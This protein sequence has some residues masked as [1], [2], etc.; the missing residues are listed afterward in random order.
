MGAAGPLDLI[1]QRT[2]LLV[3]QRLRS[4]AIVIA[5]LA[6][7][8]QEAVR[9][10]HPHRD[11][12]GAV[13]AGGLVTRWNTYRV[14]LRRARRALRTAHPA[15]VT[16]P[17]NLI[18]ERLEGPSFRGEAAPAPPTAGSETTSSTAE[19]LE[20]LQRAR[21]TASKDYGRI[22]REQLRQ[23]KGVSGPGA[24]SSLKGSP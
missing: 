4:D 5:R 8:I 3:A 12:H 24:P 6:D 20:A 21:H 23:R 17:A 13:T 11:I 2:A 9:L 10:G 14:S 22:A 7:L 1:R 19:V 15:P 18:A 16:G